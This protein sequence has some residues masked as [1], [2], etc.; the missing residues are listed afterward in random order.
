MLTAHGRPDLAGIAEASRWRGTP[1][2]T[3]RRVVASERIACVGD[4]AGYVEPFTGEGMSWAL[5]TATSLAKMVDTALKNDGDLLE[6]R[7]QHAKLVGIDRRRCHLVARLVRVPGLAHAT[8]RTIA[9]IPFLRR[10]LAG[11]ASGDPAGPSLIG[12]A[13]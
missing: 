7:R 3:R 8:I 6:W 1:A 13:R 2:L 10:R 5:Q 11:L 9:A 12:A 4:A